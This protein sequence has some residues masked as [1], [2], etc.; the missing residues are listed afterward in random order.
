MW[1]RWNVEVKRVMNE[2]KRIT[3]N[4]EEQREHRV[5]ELYPHAPVL[6]S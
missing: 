6:K 4:T 3:E 1:F 2:K 5:L